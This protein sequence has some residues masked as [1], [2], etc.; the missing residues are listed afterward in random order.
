[1]DKANYKCRSINLKVFLNQQDVNKFFNIGN[2]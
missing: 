2:F 1:M